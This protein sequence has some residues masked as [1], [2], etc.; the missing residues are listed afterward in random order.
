[1]D[2]LRQILMVDSSRYSQRLGR[3]GYFASVA[4]AGILLIAGLAVY[5][6][7]RLKGEVLLAGSWQ[8]YL[9]MIAMAYGSLLLLAVAVVEVRVRHVR[10]GVL[11][12]LTA[13]MTECQE[14]ERNE[15][16]ARLHDD[17][18][19]LLTALKIELEG[20]SRHAVDDAAEWARVD[21]L[22]DRLLDEVRGL[23]ALLYPRMM[24]RIGLKYALE[25]M[26][27][28]LCAG[29]LDVSLTT[30]GDLQ[31]LAL[32][33]SLCVL[34]VVQ[35][36]IINVRRHADAQCVRIGLTCQEGLLRGV[37]D[38][39]GRGWHQDSE[40]MGLTLMRERVRK[41]GGTLTS[42]MS[43]SGGARLRFEIPL[44]GTPHRRRKR[45]RKPKWLLSCR[46]TVKSSKKSMKTEIG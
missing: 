31:L 27:E 37:V 38:D 20:L 41:A 21:G 18:G 28:R 34:R 13:H 46:S 42:E 1:M 8:D 6:H 12:R 35:E 26:A 19:A 43:P 39:D 15:L 45:W 16:S 24:G 30:D 10:V 3:A 25:E 40:G 33:R 11:D 29:K 36:A 22:L 14:R 23:S 9:P 2:S 32:D 7:A 4:L 44:D 17:V 5:S